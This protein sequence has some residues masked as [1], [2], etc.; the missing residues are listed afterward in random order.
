ML[1]KEELKKLFENGDIPRQEDFWQWQES[2][3]HKDDSIPIEH[4]AYDFTKKADLVDGKVP[5][6][7]LPSYVDD[8]LE[9]GSYA[10]LPQ[11]GEKGK[12]Y[13]TT[14]DNK[15]YRW[16]GSTYVEIDNTQLG[17]YIPYEG[18]DRTVN[19]NSQNLQNVKHFY[20]HSG[21]Q[22]GTMGLSVINDAAGGFKSNLLIK[23]SALAGNM[24][25]FTV[26][27]YSY[28]YE[29][30]EFQINL[31]RYQENHHEPTV[32][33]KSGESTHI[34]KIEFYKDP[35]SGDFYVL[36]LGSQLGIFAYPRVA[37]TDLQAYLGDQTFN[38]DHW[39]LEWDAD[40]SSLILHSATLSEHFKKDSRAV[41]THTDQT[42]S[43]SK[44]FKRDLNITDDG[45]GINFEAGNK[46]YKKGRFRTNL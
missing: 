15:Q 4:I 14:G 6:S 44:T 25:T 3:F 5:A 31:Y 40:A 30:Y 12:I 13:I 39:K 26:K 45:L 20:S 18:A 41:S 29:F 8:V 19:L 10:E 1:N 33:W 42:I 43:G 35:A 36:I 32:N 21:I 34:G 7:Q 11:T 37:I 9:F 22:D 27:L 16:S 23:V 28:P 24:L 17:D 38:K 2:Y 46:I